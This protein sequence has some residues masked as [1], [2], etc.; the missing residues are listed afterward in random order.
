ML[1]SGLGRVV[2]CDAGHC[3]E[4]GAMVGQRMDGGWVWDLVWCG[5]G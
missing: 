1:G 2:W 5:A 4:I 3:D